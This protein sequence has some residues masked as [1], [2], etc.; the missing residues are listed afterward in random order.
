[1]FR[2]RMSRTLLTILGVSV[3]IGAILFLISMG[4]GLQQLLLEKI[5]T[6]EALL[7]LDV[8]ASPGQLVQ[9]DEARLNSFLQ[10]EGVEE[11]SPLINLPSQITIGDLTSDAMVNLVEPDYFLLSGLKP[12]LGEIFESDR[13][14]IVVSR[15]FAT[16]FGL[17][18]ENILGTEAEFFL[19]A[20]KGLE[21]STLLGNMPEIEIVTFPEKFQIV[22]LLEEENTPQVFFPLQ[23]VAHIDFPFY[24]LVKLKVAETSQLEPVR[25]RIIE[26]GFSV[27]ALS[28]VV[29]Q[30]NKVFMAFQTILGI[31]GIIALVVSAIGLFNTM[32]IS[33]L[34][35]TQE[36]GIMKSVGASRRDIANLFLTES[37]LIGFLGGVFGVI[38]GFLAG[39][40]FNFLLNILA[41]RLG[42][43]PVDLFYQPL[44]FVAT[45][46]FFSTA[47]GI[48]TGIF[49][50]RRAAK[51][52]PLS[53]IRYK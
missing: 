44:W 50:A 6:S 29:D 37:T 19:F 13:S 35:R 10:L 4:Y 11:A 16:L 5:T 39:E 12:S 51:I 2:N 22:G 43:E 33:L 46:I 8:T 34:E 23:S 24:Q 41:S 3:G 38:I 40:G 48:A 32:T 36:I 15:A 42:G 31:F 25:E 17:E 26:E 49:P 47:V 52:N 53:A 45:I 7:T 30:A 28:D 9:L 1:M 27:A 20:P 14:Q 21:N 18:E